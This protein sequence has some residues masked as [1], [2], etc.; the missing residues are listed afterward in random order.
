MKNLK[1]TKAKNNKN[2]F[3][4]KVLKDESI[5]DHTTLGI[6]G[7]A[8]YFIEVKSAED[9]KTVIGEC[10]KNLLE[11]FVI[12]GGSDLLASDEGYNG[13][14]ISNRISYL[15]M[16]ENNRF[17]CS[18]GTILQDFV[19]FVIEKGYAGLEKMSGIPGTVGGAIYGNAGAYG[20]TISD[21]ILKVI[22]FDGIKKRVFESDSCS[23]E[24]RS[25]IFKKNRCIILEAE[26][27]LEKGEKE[28]LRK[29]SLDTI[30][31]RAQKYFPGIKCPGSYF[32]NVVANT[33]AP[34]V[35]K[36]VPQDKITYGKI[37]AGFLMESVGAK[38][39][40]KGDV[41]I[42]DHHGNLII[43]MGNASAKEFLELADKFSLKVEKKFRIKLEPEVQLLGFKN[44][45]NK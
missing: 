7:P 5:A 34:S 10:R 9:L 29:I 27:A 20:Q 1:N 3:W 16:T 38:G 28:F 23:F 45:E 2:Y 42:A 41:K 32:K 19:N 22:A 33:L 43:N 25:S 6:G 13:V 8:K 30:Q 18:S 39:A 31:L 21:N 26:F 44:Y 4:K 36:L 11:Y 15:R 35:L 14:L 17:I 24:Y 37:P 40:V 12:G